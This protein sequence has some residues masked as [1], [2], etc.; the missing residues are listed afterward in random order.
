[1]IKGE[2]LQGPSLDQIAVEMIDEGC[3]GAQ[4]N[5]VYSIN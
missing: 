3:N 4:Q 2:I 5:T 1:M